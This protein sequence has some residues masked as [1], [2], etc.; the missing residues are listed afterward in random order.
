MTVINVKQKRGQLFG[1]GGGGNPQM[2]RQ[3]N[4]NFINMQ[5]R[6]KRAS[7]SETYIFR[8]QNAC[9]Y[10]QW[11]QFPYITYGMAL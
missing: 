10:L 7:A 11:M 2:Y 1:M 8:S 9:A 5:E 6:A 3:K 4:C